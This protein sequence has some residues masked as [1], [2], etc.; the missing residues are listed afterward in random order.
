MGFG[1][2]T[3][4][5]LN[6][7]ILYLFV[8]GLRRVATMRENTGSNEQNDAMLHTAVKCTLLVLIAIISTLSSYLFTTIG[9]FTVGDSFDN[10]DEIA[11]MVM[12]DWSAMDRVINSV[13]LVLQFSF[14]GK[15]YNMFC[16][17]CHL[18]CQIS[19]L[20]NSR[21]NRQKRIDIV[22]A[23]SSPVSIEPVTT[24]RSNTPE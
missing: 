24:N 10:A 14:Y 21:K 16:K 22:D 8:R 4:L 20:A 23:T 11:F 7:T 5:G 3:L 13:C 6:I 17:R 19:R 18:C 12:E 2:I 15:W 9:A 1:I